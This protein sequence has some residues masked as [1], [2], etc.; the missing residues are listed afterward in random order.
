MFLQHDYTKGRS[1]NQCDVATTW[2]EKGEGTAPAGRCGGGGAHLGGA[3][4][5]EDGDL[6]AYGGEGTS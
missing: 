2:S 6:V 5:L 4:V 3:E 1:R